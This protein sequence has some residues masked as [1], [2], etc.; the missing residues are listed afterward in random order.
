VVGLVW[1]GLFPQTVLD[2]AAPVLA[3]LNVGVSP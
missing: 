3:S 1:L 2:L